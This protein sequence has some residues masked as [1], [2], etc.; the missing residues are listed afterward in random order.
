MERIKE[1]IKEWGFKEGS[2]DFYYKSV[3]PDSIV[4][5]LFEADYVTI[6]FKAHCG[7]INEELTKVEYSYKM[8]KTRISESSKGGFKFFIKEEILRLA[9]SVHR[10]YL[11][12]E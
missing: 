2:K 12:N 10:K 5:F 8:Y 11:F 3:T 9:M 7:T 4:T 1:I 6:A